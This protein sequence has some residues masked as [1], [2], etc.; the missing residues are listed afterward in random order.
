MAE[1]DDALQ[2]V[3]DAGVKFQIGFQRRWDPR[4]LEKKKAI[5]DGKIGT[6]VL[7]KAYGRDPSAYRTLQIGA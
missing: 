2:L 4:D 5:L 3:V 6:P 1:C 7:F